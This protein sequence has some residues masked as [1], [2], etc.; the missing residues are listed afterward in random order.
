[1]DTG[2]LRCQSG[3]REA[4]RGEMMQAGSGREQSGLACHGLYRVEH[5]VRACRDRVTHPRELPWGGQDGERAGL[6][7]SD[8]DAPSLVTS[9]TQGEC[10]KPLHVTLTSHTPHTTDSDTQSVGR[11]TL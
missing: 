1:M 7:L 2:R 3:E 10:V 6:V 9:S 11:P 8:P 4:G 5:L